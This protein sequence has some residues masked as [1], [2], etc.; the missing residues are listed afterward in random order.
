MSDSLRSWLQIHFCV[1]LWGFTAILGKAISL[2]ALPLVWLRMSIVTAVLL[3]LPMFWK[4]L[5]KLSVRDVFIFAGIGVVVALHWLTFYAAIKLSNASVA[6]TCMALAPVLIAVIEPMI[7]GNRFQPRELLFGIAIV[8]G[9]ALVVGGTPVAMRLG[10]VVGVLSAA[11]VAVF[12]SLNKRFVGRGDPLCITGLE[13]GAGAVFLALI[14]PLLSNAENR[15]V[16]PDRHDGVLLLILA[17]ACT[18]LPFVLSLVALRH[19]SA[20]STAL[21]VNMEP[22]YAI[23]LAMVFFQE[24]RELTSAFYLGM[25]IVLVVVLSHPLIAAR[26][27]QT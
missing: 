27:A 9:V 13:M 10:I 22:V 3:L 23:L 25:T 2:P 26:Q 4:G 19:L 20:F 18:L 11:F 16:V 1:M 21:A 17:L 15:F 5:A 7:S 14:S 24:Q 6:A 8:P 12:G